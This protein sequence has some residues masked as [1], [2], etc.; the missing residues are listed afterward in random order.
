MVD[1]NKAINISDCIQKEADYY[2]KARAATD[3][4]IRSAYEST[5]REYGDRAKRLRE[6]KLQ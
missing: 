1:V 4:G 6:E 5:A 3:P 2:R